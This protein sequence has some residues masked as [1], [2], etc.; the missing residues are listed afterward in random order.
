MSA[1]SYLHRLSLAVNARDDELRPALC[2]FLL[3][4]CLFTGYFM[5]RRCAAWPSVSIRDCRAWMC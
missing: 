5:L 2:G 3:F 1:P 4:L